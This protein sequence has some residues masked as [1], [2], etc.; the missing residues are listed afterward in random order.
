MAPAGAKVNYTLVGE[1]ND[2]AALVPI[3]TDLLVASGD[4]L[5]EVTWAD[6]QWFPREGPAQLSPLARRIAQASVAYPAAIYFVHRDADGEDPTP[7]RAEVIEAAREV[8]GV[9]P[10]DCLAVVP[11]QELEA[12][13]MV[14]AGAI[15]KAAARTAGE[16]DVPAKARLES[17]AHPKE[18]LSELLADLGVARREYSAAKRLIAERMDWKLLRGLT[19]FDMLEGDV[20][21]ALQRAGF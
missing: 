11:V 16:V 12:W 4:D 14:D 17:I 21:T 19:A 15:R 8:A 7:R 2:D 6:P 3:L 20:Q 13:L 1:G 18:R 10:D 5:A 9:L